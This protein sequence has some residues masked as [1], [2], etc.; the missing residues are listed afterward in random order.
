MNS[1]YL[2]LLAGTVVGCVSLSDNAV[3]E[4]ATQSP[5]MTVQLC[6]EV[7]RGR[8]DKSALLQVRTYSNCAADWKYSLTLIQF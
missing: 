4:P 5:F 8:N 7:C 2:V 6:V 1:C 3:L